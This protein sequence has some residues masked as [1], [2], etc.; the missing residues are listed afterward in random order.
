MRRYI[1]TII[2]LL[3][4]IFVF[5]LIGALQNISY[6]RKIN[7]NMRE[8]LFFKKSI[9]WQNATDRESRYYDMMIQIFN[10]YSWQYDSKYKRAM[11]KEQ[12]STY[13]KLNWK[14]ARAM[15]F[16]PFA[17]PVIHQMESCFNPYAK[18]V[19]GEMGIAGI[20]WDTGLLA[21]K[22]VDYMPAGYKSIMYPVDLKTPMDLEDP[23]LSLKLT[24]VLLWYLRRQFEGR[25]D[26]Y[27][28][29]Y[30]WGGFLSRHWNNGDGEVPTEFK[31]NG[32]SYDVFSYY[33]TFKEMLESYEAG[34]IEP[35]RPIIDKW[36]DYYA[37]LTKEEIDFR[38]TASII[39]K[40]RRELRERKEIEYELNKKYEEI[41]K[42]L[43]KANKQLKKISGESQS[44]G[45]SAL[46]KVRETA[47]NLINEI[48]GKNKKNGDKS[49][50]API[51]ERRKKR[52]E[53]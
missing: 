17:V 41:E 44:K 23:I 27:I 43:E 16:S 45:K 26:W 33:Q 10:T 11:T 6:R 42:E 39:K 7:E 49:K 24:Y 37:K 5:L 4:C 48:S 46:I 50:E 3:V 51:P 38:M 14:L 47:K 29:V 8:I 22:L 34:E 25:E 2:M 19:Y 13:M 53:K 52:I 31:L 36:Q 28:L 32:K 12:K 35:A 21:F 15:D 9:D 1:K 40:L 20:K 18:H 30:H